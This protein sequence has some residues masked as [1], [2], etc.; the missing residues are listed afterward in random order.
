MTRY[1]AWVDG[2]RRNA[3]GI[4]V[5]L[6]AGGA[7]VAGSYAAAGFTAGFVAAPIANEM[8]KLMPGAVVTVAI[9]VLGDLG[10]KLNLL[11]AVGMAAG[12]F[13]AAAAVGVVVERRRDSTAA[14]ALA[15]AG[16][17]A[18]VALL[19]TRSLVPAAAAGLATG[20]VLAGS[21]LALVGGRPGV[22]PGTADRRA[23]LKG[24]AVA[25]GIGL[26][27]GVVGGAGRTDPPET[28]SS[29]EADASVQALLDDADAKSLDVDGMEP[30]VSED[31]Y[32]VDIATVN[33]EVRADEW[34]LSVTGAVNE[35]HTVDYGT[36]TDMASEHRFVTLRCVGERLNGKKTDNALWTG[37]PM[38]A[39]L[40]EVSPESGCECVMLRAADDYFE[41]FPLS[42]L[43]RGFLAYGMNG[44]ALPRA[45]GYPVRALVPGHWGEINVKWLTEIEFL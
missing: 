16:G 9:L 34:E 26:F 39:L 25:G 22:D 44:R 21:R 41:E 36:L 18:G 38:S 29:P 42:A 4:A 43:K 37:V 7:G 20:A 23:A 32:T 33:P 12:M 30:L 5:A 10:Q 24:L 45:H 6:L 11:S 31:F 19:L 35:E 3:A 15:A 1:A 40:S 14:G 17:S 2:L 13:A 28:G 8:A 27:G